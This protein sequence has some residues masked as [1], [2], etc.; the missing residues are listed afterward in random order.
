MAIAEEERH[1]A[2][3][4]VVGGGGEGNSATTDWGRNLASAPFKDHAPFTARRCPFRN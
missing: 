3:T 1:E 4:Q 2:S